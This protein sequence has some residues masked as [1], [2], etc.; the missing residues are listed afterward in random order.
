MWLISAVGKGGAQI[1]Q[2]LAVIILARLLAPSDFGLIA[3]V[4]A[5][6][7]VANLFRDLGLSAA[8][9]RAKEIT[10]SQASALMYINIGFGALMTIIVF[11]SAP[12]IASF[13][14]DDRIVPIAHALAWSF[15]LG[16]LGTQHLALLRRQLKFTVL[17]WLNLGAVV[18]GQGVAVVLAFQEFGYWA[19][20]VG[21]LLTQFSKALMAW[22]VNDWRPGLPVFDTNV[23]RMFFFGGH[24]MIFSLMGYI[25]FNVHSVVIGWRF[26]ADDVGFYNRAFTIITLLIGY[27]VAPLSLVAPAALARMTDESKNYNETYLHTVSMMLLLTA[28]IGFVSVVA[29][30]DIVAVVLGGGWQ[31]S[32]II[33]QILALAAIPQTLCSSSGWLYLSHGDSK[34]MMQWGIGGWGALI[35]F[36]TVG[37]LYGIKGVASAYTLGMFFLLYPCMRLA[38][39]RTTLRFNDLLK[40]TWPIATPAFIA[41]IP[42]IYANQLFASWSVA[43][44]FPSVLIVYGSVYLM[45]L[46]FVFRQGPLLVD[47]GQQVL[48]RKAIA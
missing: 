32:V 30:S 9:V 39:R 26:G 2:L 44:R 18:I 46:L 20:V 19:L 38:F 8:T 16:S 24:L 21:T 11:L 48:K 22:I 28:P 47:V 41:S 23:R 12:M 4:M 31:E 10:P 5:I 27:V 33:L 40:V 6:I 29:A 36:V 25:A 37:T 14:D 42:M 35:I 43:W 15:L 7:G 45:L 3:M 1:V 34:S 13:Y 17:A